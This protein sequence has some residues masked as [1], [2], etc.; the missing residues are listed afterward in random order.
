MGSRPLDRALSPSQNAL[1]SSRPG[2]TLSRIKNR[3]SKRESNELGRLMFSLMALRLLYL[4][5]K[6]FAA[7]STAARAFSVVVIPA[8]AMLT[9]CCSITCQVERRRRKWPAC[10]TGCGIRASD[11]ISFGDPRAKLVLRGGQLIRF[12]D[13]QDESG[14]LPSGV[15]ASKSAFFSPAESDVTGE[16]YTNYAE[17]HNVQ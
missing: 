14:P 11:E 9:V 13:Q 7:A 1:P 15:S 5:Y 6:G 8:L 16:I 17:L 12:H 4:P 2:P 10:C 3:R